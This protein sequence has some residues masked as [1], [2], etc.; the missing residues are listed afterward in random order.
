M[1]LRSLR[2]AKP[3][4]K[5]SPDDPQVIENR[6]PIRG[7]GRVSRVPVQYVVAPDDEGY[8]ATFSV[9]LERTSAEQ[10]S[11]EL[12]KAIRRYQLKYQPETL[13]WPQ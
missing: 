9:N 5:A 2:T 7:R 10:G 13:R 11:H 12:L 8:A 4:P 1:R 3:G 6:L